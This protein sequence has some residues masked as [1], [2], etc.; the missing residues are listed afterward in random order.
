MVACDLAKVRARVRFSVPAPNRSYSIMV[1]HALGKGEPQ[2]QFSLGAP[3]KPI[4]PPDG[5]R[6]PGL[7]YNAAL[8]DVVIA[9][10]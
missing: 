7:L 6:V 10:D 5:N 4:P 8:A 3:L 2:V 9:T 1:I